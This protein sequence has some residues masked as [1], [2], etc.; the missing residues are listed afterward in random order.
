MF[1]SQFDTNLAPI[2]WTKT[3]YFSQV[4]E[5]QKNNCKIQICEKIKRHEKSLLYCKSLKIFT[6]NSLFHN[7]I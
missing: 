6:V 3:G 5:I 1:C 7:P 4:I 2:P